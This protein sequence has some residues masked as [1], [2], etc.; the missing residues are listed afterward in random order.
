MIQDD[1]LVGA[2]LYGD[3][4]D[5]GWYFKLLED[6]RRID[7]LRDQLMF[8]E[9]A[10]GDAGHSGQSRAMSMP[11]SD[12][13]CGSRV[14]KGTIV[15]AITGN[16]LFTLDD[17]EKHTK[18][19]SSCGSCTGLVEQILMNTLGSSFQQTPKTRAVCE[20]TDF[21]HGEVRSDRITC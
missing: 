17:V 4:T 15:K 3:T 5:G 20:C 2:C 12:E 9:S 6:G 19:S 10:I 1:K 7:D 11:D 21:A 8:G 16:G 18:A 13:V 14:C